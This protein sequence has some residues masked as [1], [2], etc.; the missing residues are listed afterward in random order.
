MRGLGQTEKNGKFIEMKGGKTRIERAWLITW[1]RCGDHARRADPV[2]AILDYRFL[3]KRVCALVEWMYLSAMYSLNPRTGY[4]TEKMCNRYPAQFGK[5][6]DGVPWE[7]EII[8]GNNPFL[9]ARLVDNL[10]VE[11]DAEGKKK[12]S[13]NERPQPQ[14]TVPPVH[15]SAASV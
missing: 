11:W 9:K 4:A 13:W 7:E 5:T 12:T 6:P 3:P 15:E 10:A 8:C 1:E 2:A 14:D